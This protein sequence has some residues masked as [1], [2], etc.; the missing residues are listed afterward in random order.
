MDLFKLEV[1][2]LPFLATVIFLSPLNFTVPSLLIVDRLPAVS[3]SAVKF[4]VYAFCE[5]ALLIASATFLAS[6]IPVAAVAV[7]LV[8]LISFL[9]ADTVIKLPLARVVR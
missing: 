4:Q 3:L 5:T 7:P 6:A 9:L 1:M 2:V 8:T